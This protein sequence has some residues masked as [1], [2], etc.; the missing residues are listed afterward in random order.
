[1][2]KTRCCLTFEER[3]QIWVMRSKGRGIR[4]ISRFLGR[5]ASVVSRELRR[6]GGGTRMGLSGLERARYAHDRAKRR[7]QERKRGKRG[8]IRLVVVR[9][10]IVNRL[11]DKFSPEAIA[12][13]MEQ[14]IGKK[15]SCSTIYRWIK[16]E[17]PELK[18]HL[19]ERGKKRRQRVMN[20]R[21]VFQ[22]AAPTKRSYDSRPEAAKSRLDLGHLEGDTIHSC[23]GSKAAVVSIR[24]RKSRVQ[25]FEKVEDLKAQTVNRAIV[26]I[27][28]RIPVD[29][30]KTVTFDRGSEF[31]EWEMIEK[32]FHEIVTYFCDPFSPYQK[33]TNERGNRDLRKYFPKGTDFAFVTDEQLREAE[34]KINKNPMKL[35]SWSAPYEVLQQLSKAA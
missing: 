32:I 1:M 29:L 22:Q 13:T 20:R 19:Y 18:H 5:D 33:G 34:I 28:N 30:H 26:R 3:Q 8:A 16:C 12:N 15:I 9:E 14:E 24:D 31:A 4:E 11:I 27:F 10:H 7:L 6:N 23:K 21:G 25:W 35:H 2:K 17:M